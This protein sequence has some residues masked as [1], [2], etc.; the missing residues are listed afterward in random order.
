MGCQ[1]IWKDAPSQYLTIAVGLH[2][3]LLLFILDLNCFRDQ[4][5]PWIPHSKPSSISPSLSIYFFF[6]YFFAFLFF[7][8]CSDYFRSH[9]IVSPGSVVILFS[10]SFDQCELTNIII[11]RSDRQQVFPRLVSSL[12]PLLPSMI[13]FRLTFIAFFIVDFFSKISISPFLPIL[14]GERQWWEIDFPATRGITEL[15]LFLGDLSFI[16]F[17]F[18]FIIYF[19]ILQTFLNEHFSHLIAI[20]TPT[21]FFQFSPEGT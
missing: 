10:P 8:Y 19:G 6:C 2:F 11:N 18:F 4:I 1:L 14:G 9:F 21:F 12:P 20:H 13:K 17:D 3:P 15:V 5:N 16:Y 7:F